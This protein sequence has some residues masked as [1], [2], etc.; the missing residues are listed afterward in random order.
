MSKVSGE[1]TKRLNIVHILLMIIYFVIFA[2]I[3]IKANYSGEMVWYSYYRVGIIESLTDQIRQGLIPQFL[4][5]MVHSWGFT[6][7]LPPIAA[8]LGIQDFYAYFLGIQMTFSWI[9]LVVFPLEIYTI[10]RSKVLAII[11]PVLLHIF[12][13]NALYGFKTDTFWPSGFAM[14]ICLPLIIYFFQINGQKQRRII[15]II[16]GSVCSLSNILRNQN[17]FPVLVTFYILLLTE[18]LKNGKWKNLKFWLYQFEIIIIFWIF[19]NLIS[20]YV[21]LISGYL[22]G[23]GKLN[24]EGF[25]W[26]SILCGWGVFDNP[27]GLAWDDSVIYE[28]IHQKYG[29]SE[30]YSDK[31][32]NDCKQYVLDI[33]IHNPTF[34]LK[35][36][37]RKF[38]ICVQDIINRL[39]IYEQYGFEHY[40]YIR[41]NLSNIKIPSILSA[42]ALVIGGLLNKLQIKKHMWNMLFCITIIILFLI[43]GTVNGVLGY[44]YYPNYFIGSIVA[45]GLIP[46]AITMFVVYLLMDKC[47]GI[48]RRRT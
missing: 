2:T 1:S 32:I 12:C 11:S 28:I 48:L 45:V 21:P 26:H 13:G 33:L 43:L 18:L 6:F 38:V 40:W 19:Y 39:F 36:W 47:K 14:I 37:L 29:Y 35:T 15:A 22:L 3:V 34:A 46:M 5:Q 24:N 27:Y 9:L 25:V 23:Q 41:F 42:I 17:A 10:F 20:S 7:Y 30:I 4:E 44:C 8:L 31:Y 16:I